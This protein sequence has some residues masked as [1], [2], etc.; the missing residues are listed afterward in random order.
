MMSDN[1]KSPS[2]DLELEDL[3]E[4]GVWVKADS[5][6]SLEEDEAVEDFLDIE[7]LD[8]SL[9]E[10]ESLLT[11]EEEDLLGMLEDGNDAMQSNL[12]DNT[13]KP[14]TEEE[15]MSDMNQDKEQDLSFEDEQELSDA[16]V[17]LNSME[18]LENLDDDSFTSLDLDD[19][20]PDL[21]EESLNGDIS[22]DLDDGV[23]DSEEDTFL[24]EETLQLDLEDSS[25]ELRFDDLEQDDDISLEIPD[26]DDDLTIPELD[27]D[28]IEIPSLDT[29]DQLVIPEVD[30]V[31]DLE[32]PTLD[33]LDNQLDDDLEEITLD[34]EP[35]D[36]D[37]LEESDD[38]TLPSMDEE[39]TLNISE[40]LIEDTLP[41]LDDL[42][43]MD[44][45]FLQLDEEGLDLNS[46][47]KDQD[48]DYDTTEL[49]QSV[50]QSVLPDD[51]ELLS[52]DEESE[53]LDISIE[54]I[55]DQDMS[56][57]LPELDDFDDVE[58]FAEE[59]TE[60]SL[61]PQTPIISN[62]GEPDHLEHE[63][64]KNQSS[65]TI[66]VDP[67]SSI[68]SSIES[69]LSAIKFELTSLREELKQLRSEEQKLRSSLA[70][71]KPAYQ[72]PEVESPTPIN[73]EQ[74]DSES[75]ESLSNDQNVSGFSDLS[76]DDQTEE[77][78]FEDSTELDPTEQTIDQE[79][80]DFV[81]GQIDEIEIPMEEDDLSNMT[82][83]HVNLQ[84]ED[85]QFSQTPEDIDGLTE[86]QEDELV[87]EEG[88]GG[89]FDDD[90][91]ETIALTGDELDNILN[92]AEFIEEA[93]KPSEY[94]EEELV[95]ESMFENVDDE[96]N[97]EVES[98]PEDELDHTTP[99]LDEEIQEDT[100]Q[101]SF[102]ESIG[103]PGAQQDKESLPIEEILSEEE[104]VTDITL[105]EVQ[106][107]DPGLLEHDPF[108]GSEDAIKEMAEL[109]IDKELE[110]IE[111]L[112]DEVEQ[113]DFDESELEKMSIEI[114]DS[115]EDVV[116][117]SVPDGY[118]P[119]LSLEE[120]ALLT[121]E[122]G[123]ED[124]IVL[125]DTEEPY[126][127]ELDTDVTD[128]LSL[129]NN[130]KSKEFPSTEQDGLS[131]SLKNE[132]KSV[133]AYMDKLLEALP[134]EKIEE[135]ARS[136][137]FEVYKRLFEELGL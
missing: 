27:D 123:E 36:Q 5:D 65:G 124:P 4:Y 52:M 26:L 82:T 47:Q 131:A 102:E 80:D 75:E 77:Y 54:D 28:E 70:D 62:L 117:E 100:D 114:P 88:A 90:E 95:D 120:E 35:M 37:V 99:E 129:L 53:P 7:E 23:F 2:E 33:D 76:T 83:H 81:D 134:E 55:E 64:A 89:F 34:I 109:D 24:E 50:D 91:D 17:E 92:T 29:S 130:E 13:K 78:S 94:T 39:E 38:M 15:L 12:L 74:I 96:V 1:T 121:E 67:G 11:E 71:V 104:D 97:L 41:D 63:S 137:H 20:E 59:L 116:P 42:P 58:A 93:G 133:L 119:D 9:L 128:P 25:E 79:I 125:D 132:I 46:F 6:V 49:S 30:E 103:K 126:T 48:T 60:E 43:D 101:I 21:S 72:E 3:D 44:E 32:M 118:E 22:L 18:D 8:D 110:G 98:E 10:E 66:S 136:E 107:E 69:E 16:S 19:L 68:L 108:G 86:Q 113:V 56:E 45:D 112:E 14:E 85:E 127:Q 40:D 51:E 57:E 87:L 73:S 111:N 115:F 84:Q 31:D 122:S 105:E 106:P 135:F 61:E